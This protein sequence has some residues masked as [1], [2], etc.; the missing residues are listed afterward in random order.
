LF[1]ISGG[2]IKAI[3]QFVI[4]QPF[5]NEMAPPQGHK[6]VKLFQA[7]YALTADLAT[8]PFPSV[9]LC[10]GVWMGFGVGLA[11]FLDRRVVTEKTTFAM[12][13]CAIGANLF[14]CSEH[15]D[16]FLS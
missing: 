12:P 8:L 3:R 16:G 9:A 13:E 1:L 7:E 15:K 4:D 14:I 6:V 2:D 5:E 11:G 10:H